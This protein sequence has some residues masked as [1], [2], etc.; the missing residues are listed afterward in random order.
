MTG[1]D[2]DNPD[3]ENL[4]ALRRQIDAVDDRLLAVLA[5]RTRLV[6]R[7]AD[8]KPP[9]G[10]AVPAREE[11]ILTRLRSRARAHGIDPALVDAVWPPLFSAFRRMQEDHHN[12]N[13]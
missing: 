12:R 4:D 11:A 13:L 7:A 1:R 2:A 10:V 5:E 6:L 9:G 8:L 3:A